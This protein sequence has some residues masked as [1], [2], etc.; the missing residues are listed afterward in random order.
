MHIEMYRCIGDVV[1]K[2]AANVVLRS[3]VKRRFVRSCEYRGSK[4]GCRCRKLKISRKEKMLALT[5]TPRTTRKG[6][7]TFQQMPSSSNCK[8]TLL[9]ASLLF[10]GCSSS[11]VDDTGMHA[12]LVTHIHPSAFIDHNIKHLLRIISL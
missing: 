9:Q 10:F 4:T 3:I 2:R 1:L 11:S 8:S 7:L 12:G 5:G 6:S